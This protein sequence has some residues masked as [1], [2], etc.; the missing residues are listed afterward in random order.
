MKND[1]HERAKRLIDLDRVDGLRADDRAWLQTHL[2][3]CEDC[4]RWTSRTDAALRALINVPVE[5]PPG[6]AA[7][8]SY[9]VRREA[10]MR[11]Q[12]RARSLGLVAGCT[13][14]WVLGAASAP[15]VWKIFAWLGDEFDLPRAIWMLG[16]AAWWLV[17]AS[18]AALLILWQRERL[19][20]ESQDGAL[21]QH[22]GPE[23]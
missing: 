22:H 20:R 1:C 16:F 12:R 6:L 5:I 3:E 17:P 19:E 4:E 11:N 10:E 9:R 7:A 14:S 21:E 2:G 18:A 23:K 13:L 8:A 15:L